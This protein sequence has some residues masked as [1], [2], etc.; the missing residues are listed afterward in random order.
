MA[1]SFLWLLV[2]AAAYL[3]GSVPFG[4]LIGRFNGLD[5]RQ[6]GSGNIGATNVLRV[7]GRPWGYACFV[8]DFLKGCL[9][10]LAA[11]QLASRPEAGDGLLNGLSPLLAAAGTVA[12]HIWPVYLR[13]KGGKGVATMIGTVIPLAPLPILAAVAG[14][15]LTFKLSRYVSLASIVAAALLP[16]AAAALV[17]TRAGGFKP[18]PLLKPALEQPGLLLLAALGVLVIVKHHA[19]IRR[20][21]NGTENRFAKK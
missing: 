21:L 7:I 8:L 13:F 19:N 14:W 4:Y 15:L 10:V 17:F 11:I 20:L 12:G 5:I 9:P 18:F 3:I 6:H 1:W 16:L 2:L